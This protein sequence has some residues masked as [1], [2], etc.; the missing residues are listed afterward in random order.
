MDG[1]WSP[2]ENVLA[3]YRHS[4]S[5]DLCCIDASCTGDFGDVAV[6]VVAVAVVASLIDKADIAARVLAMVAVAPVVEFTG[7]G[8]TG[9]TPDV[10][11]I[12]CVDNGAGVLAGAPKSPSKLNKPAALFF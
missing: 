11:N 1:G 5:K 9:E 12:G 6:V 4:S 2:K 8:I 7:I 10:G 3:V